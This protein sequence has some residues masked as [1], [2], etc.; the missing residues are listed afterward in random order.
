MPINQSPRGCR[1]QLQLQTVSWQLQHT[2]CTYCVHGT[3][4]TVWVW[5][6]VSVHVVL[7][8][9]VDSADCMRATKTLRLLCMHCCGTHAVRKYHPRNMQLL[10]A[11]LSPCG[12]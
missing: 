8:L 7:V 11:R 1:Q 10:G 4:H 6:W 3:V 9:F 2:H 12:M 5:V